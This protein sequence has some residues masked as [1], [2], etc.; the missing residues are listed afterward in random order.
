MTPLWKEWI[1]QHYGYS[2]GEVNSVASFLSVHC[3]NVEARHF[4]HAAQVL[5]SYAEATGQAIDY[6][7][8]GRLSNEYVVK[9][10]EHLDRMASVL[11]H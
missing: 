2:A 1:K 8:I 7:R 5:R 11:K 6:E 3:G 10:C 9:A 4:L